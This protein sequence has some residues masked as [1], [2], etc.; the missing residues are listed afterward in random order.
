MS[1]SWRVEFLLLRRAAVT[2]LAVVLLVV[3][4]PLVGVGV[5]RVA[6]GS[7]NGTLALKVRPMMPGEGWAGQLGLT[8]QILS[9]AAL[10]VGAF[11]VSWTFGREFADGTAE[12]TVLAGPRPAVTAS[13]KLV[14][15]AV[16]VCGACV[17]GIVVAVGV[18][19]L[20]GTGPLSDAVGP[21]LRST[22]GAVLMVV[23]AAPFAWAASAGR[24]A[25]TGV[26]AA[27]GV[28]V[29]TE[30]LTAL[31]TGGWFPY[32]APGLWLGMGG[33]GVSASA[34]QL[35]LAVPVGI[36]G[37]V[38]TAWWWDRAEIAG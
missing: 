10:L 12:T 23:L 36:A 14:A 16:V 29:V 11:V 22:V 13:A 1:G 26:G 33:P 38:G 31:G 21:A 25:L 19:A 6:Q 24:S 35:L 30:I 34:L 8:G 4:I 20:A 17:A 9:V 18:G 28:L 7:G 5:T 2:R 37:W 27:I 15:A 32:A 3:V